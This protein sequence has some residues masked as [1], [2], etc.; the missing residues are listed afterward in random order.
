MK[1]GFCKRKFGVTVRC[2]Y[3]EVDYCTGC[4]QL[5]VHSCKNIHKKIEKDLKIL[6][7]KNTKI[8]TP[9]I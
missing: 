3:C 8:S 9:K 2:V 7:D 1:C 4:I 6:E 5:E